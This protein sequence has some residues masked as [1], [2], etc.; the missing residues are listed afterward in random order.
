MD[1][2]PDYWCVVDC[3]N[4]VG[5]FANRYFPPCHHG[6]QALRGANS[7][8]A[9]FSVAGVVGGH[10]V[11]VDNWLEAATLYNELHRQGKIVCVPYLA[12]EK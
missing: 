4:R 1:K 10:Q 6:F 7:R 2:L 12:T 9:D 3:G 5:I 8:C 11:R